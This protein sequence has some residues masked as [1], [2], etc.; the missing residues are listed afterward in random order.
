METEL[1]RVVDALPGL[2]WTARLDGHIDF[3]N[4]RWSEYTGRSVDE[5]HGRAWQTVLHPEDLPEL[6]ERWRSIVASGQPG[7]MEARLRH[8]DGEYRWFLFRICPLADASGRVVKWC[9]M[10]I[11]IE[12]RKRAEDALRAHERRFRSIVDGFPA[13]VALRTP[14]GDLEFANRRYLE[15]FNATLEKLKWARSPWAWGDNIHPDDRP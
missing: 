14:A 8:F 13:L 5:A 6:L 4:Q 2:V 11:D 3:L 12:D 7:E 1:R 10:S 15:Y 9:G